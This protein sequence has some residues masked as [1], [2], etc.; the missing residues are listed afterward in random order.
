MN[1]RMRLDETLR[2]G[3]GGIRREHSRVEDDGLH[4]RLRRFGAARTPVAGGRGRDGVKTLFF[5][6]Y[7]CVCTCACVCAFES[8]CVYESVLLQSS[9]VKTQKDGVTGFRGRRRGTQAGG[10]DPGGRGACIYSFQLE[11]NPYLFFYTT[12]N[13]KPKKELKTQDAAS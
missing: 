12:H 6:P 4:E 9:G 1:E 11:T 7:V 13:V 5:F 8:V 2:G 3:G 10:W